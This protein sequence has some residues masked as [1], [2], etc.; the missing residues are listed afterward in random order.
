MFLTLSPSRQLHFS[1]GPLKKDNLYCL[2]CIEQASILLCFI[3]CAP[4]TLLGK[5]EL[6]NQNLLTCEVSRSVTHDMEE[7]VL[8]KDCTTVP[9]K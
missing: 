6:L 9:P 5:F 3:V 1:S 2:Y 4:H 7:G 8:V